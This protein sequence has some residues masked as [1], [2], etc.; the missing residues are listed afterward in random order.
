MTVLTYDRPGTRSSTSQLEQGTYLPEIL[1]VS[2]SLDTDFHF[3]SS[4]VQEPLNHFKSI[5]R[6]M[7]DH[8]LPVVLMPTSPNRW[9]IVCWR[10]SRRVSIAVGTIILRGMMR[11]LLPTGDRAR[12]ESEGVLFGL[13]NI[14]TSYGRMQEVA[15]RWRPSGALHLNHATPNDREPARSSFM[16]LQWVY[17]Q[18]D[19]QPTLHIISQSVVSYLI[20]ARA[21]SMS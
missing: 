3:Q 15:I 14:Q 18:V 13:C 20:A 9:W 19:A 5:L 6:R 2:S 16:G 4:Q 1:P 11:S 21:A 12:I 17:R 10:G 8:K 7:I